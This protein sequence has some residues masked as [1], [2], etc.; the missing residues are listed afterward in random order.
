MQI[1]IVLLAEDISAVLR[2]KVWT[3]AFDWDAMAT[4]EAQ[5]PGA[6][7]IRATPK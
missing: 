1:S 7:C 3:G 6:R 4:A 5:R 2:G